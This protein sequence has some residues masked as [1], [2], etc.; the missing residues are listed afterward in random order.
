[1]SEQNLERQIDRLSK[2][3]ADLRAALKPFADRADLYD[4]SDEDQEPTGIL[5][6]FRRARALLKG[7]T[8]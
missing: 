6:H 1:M 8:P 5:G 7:E 4:W 2:E 3:N